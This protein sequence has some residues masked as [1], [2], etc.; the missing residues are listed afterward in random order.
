MKLSKKLP[1]LD[2]LDQVD[3]HTWV[4]K[5][6]NVDQWEFMGLA[7]R[8]FDQ[9]QGQRFKVTQAVKKWVIEM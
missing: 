3:C 8:G 2:G 6:E 7:H 9:S 1:A 4:I 5:N